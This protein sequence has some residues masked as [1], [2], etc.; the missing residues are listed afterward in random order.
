MG[1]IASCCLILG[2]LG[3]SLAAEAQPTQGALEVRA[4]LSTIVFTRV[5]EATFGPGDVLPQR[6]ALSAGWYF[7]DT[8]S[9]YLTLGFGWLAHPSGYDATSLG[10]T[11]HVAFA[12]PFFL[13]FGGLA[14]LESFAIKVFGGVGLQL[15]QDA[16]GRFSVTL[17]LAEI[18][19]GEGGV[20]YSVGVVLGGSYAF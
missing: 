5:G 8:L 1:R 19:F 10:T 18:T 12:R 15:P 3:T 20:G 4:D 9:G 2:L 7:S 13:R 16:M 17:D 14:T 6:L 11:W